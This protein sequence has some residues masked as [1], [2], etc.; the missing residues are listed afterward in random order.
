MGVGKYRQLDMEYPIEDEV[1]LSEAD[2][3]RIANQFKRHNIS[4]EIVRH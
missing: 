2:L 3:E 4:V 1:M